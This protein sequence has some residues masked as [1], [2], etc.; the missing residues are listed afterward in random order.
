MPEH[1]PPSADV[2]QTEQLAKMRRRIRVA[3]WKHV[4]GWYALGLTAIVLVFTVF[5]LQAYWLMPWLCGSYAALV[6]HGHTTYADRVYQSA[7]AA[8][9][10]MGIIASTEKH[11]HAMWHMQNGEP[12]CE[13]SGVLNVVV[14][15]MWEHQFVR[16]EIDSS[17]PGA[18]RFAKAGDDEDDEEGG[19]GYR[20]AY[21]ER[22]HP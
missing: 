22:P 15:H 6:I 17:A 1:V 18:F 12:P 21:N 10:A 16:E 13:E 20:D 8:G 2:R 9:L 4:G 5:L 3:R 19:D 14:P 7:Y 11:H